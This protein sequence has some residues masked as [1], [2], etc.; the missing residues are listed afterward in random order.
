VLEDVL[1]I[2]RH[3]DPRRTL[4]L[5]IAA[6]EHAFRRQPES[7]LPQLVHERIA[8]VR[9]G[10]RRIS[11]EVLHERAEA[12]FAHAQRHL[13]VRLGVPGFGF[14]QRAPDD[15]REALKPVLEHV[16]GRAGLHRLHG[17]LFTDR[18]RDEN[19][20][21]VGNALP[22]DA[23]RG[24]AVQV[25]RHAEIAEDYVGRA[26]RERAF[27]RVPCAYPLRVEAQSRVAQLLLTK[28][29][30]QLGIFDKQDPQILVQ[31]AY[32]RAQRKLGVMLRNTV[33]S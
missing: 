22:G 31:H 28:L 23:Q 1:K 21:N 4:E 33:K 19:E 32:S 11:R 6:A 3:R 18:A 9:V 29:G 14:L 2:D 17:T 16:V 5:V 8:A 10:N 13:G 27:Q 7:L 30:V 15:G 25:G 12:G 24:H 26:L 20:R